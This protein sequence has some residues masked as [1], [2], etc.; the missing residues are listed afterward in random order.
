MLNKI[1]RKTAFDDF[2]AKREERKD[3]VFGLLLRASYGY[4]ETEVGDSGHTGR[5]R[6]SQQR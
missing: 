6:K 1:L 4:V 3:G 2:L 5:N